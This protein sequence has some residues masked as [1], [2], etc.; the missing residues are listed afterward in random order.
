[1]S[2]L[3][4]HHATQRKESVHTKNAIDELRCDLLKM[5]VAARAL[6]NL[7]S[8]HTGRHRERVARQ[9]A[10][11]VHR[12][13]RGNHLHDFLL[14]ACICPKHESKGY[15]NCWQQ[16]IQSLNVLFALCT[17]V[18]LHRHTLWIL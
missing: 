1:M 10:R 7:E 16:D 4:M 17:C 6:Q 2:H 12:A 3:W 5:L 14:A 15:R 11:L 13:C 8:L 9:G 18:H